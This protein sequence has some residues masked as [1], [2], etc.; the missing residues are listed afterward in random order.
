MGP[1]SK[2]HDSGFLHLSRLT[3]TELLP[4][5]SVLQKAILGC[6]L[7]NHRGKADSPI[8][9]DHLV[10]LLNLHLSPLS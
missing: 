1:S 6:G 2:N 5:G 7:I 4:A 9:A 10:E 3:A 8:E